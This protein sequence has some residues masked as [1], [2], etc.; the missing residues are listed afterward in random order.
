[1]K[2]GIDI[3]VHQGSIN[4][5]EVAKNI[6]FAI[7]RVG[8]GVSYLPDSQKDKKFEEYY[9]GL[10][11]KKPIGAYYY[12]YAN[13]IGEGKKEAENCLKYL[14]GKKLELPIYY[15]LE[16]SS[17]DNVQEVAR[18]FVDTIKQAGY[19][20]GIYCNM[21]WARNVIDLSQFQDCSIW[22]A[23]YGS[24]NGQIPSSKPDINYNVWQYTSVGRISGIS[25][26]V[27]MN[28]ADDSFTSNTSGSEPTN[29]KSTDEIAQ[30]VIEGKWGNGDERK[31][32]LTEAGY[33]YT[34]IQNRVNQILANDKK[35]VDE[36]AQEVIAGQWGNGQERK[37]RLTEAGYNAEEVQNRVNEI[38]GESTEQTYTVK[39]G[40]TLSAI[41]K[42]YNT[43]VDSLVQK[44][45]IKNPNL[46]YPGQVLKI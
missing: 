23:M 45:G 11:G 43:T 3:S 2:T 38:L 16:D 35:S 31:Q 1:M 19:K 22:I 10:H 32:R 9:A 6:D 44:N 26:N 20:A 17:M 29:K 28:I 36:I 42:K 21:N 46:I 12:A 25:G 34:T 15:D 13:E 5:D 30:E 40:D 33:D 37:D 27:D 24:N 39:S 41:A 7:L 14:D 4:C 8:Y 18:E